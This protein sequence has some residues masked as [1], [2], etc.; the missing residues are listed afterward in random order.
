MRKKSD[1]DSLELLLDTIC[2]IFGGIILMAIL[3]VVQIN[4]SVN[5]MSSLSKSKIVIPEYSKMEFECSNLKTLLIQRESELSQLNVRVD[6]SSDIYLIMD[7][8]LKV[9]EAINDL[10]G[11]NKSLGTIVSEYRKQNAYYSE[12][13][14]K[15]KSELAALERQISEEN[16]IAD[17]NKLGQ[18]KQVRLPFQHQSFAMKSCC[19]VVLHDK[20]YLLESNYYSNIP[21][22]AGQCMVY[23]ER[24]GF[25][26]KPIMDSGYGVSEEMSDAFETSIKTYNAIG[27]FVHA[28][29]DSF[30]SFQ[31]IKNYILEKGYMY[32]VSPYDDSGLVVELVDDMPVE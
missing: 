10:V 11:D 22:Q 16:I 1:S 7:Q 28:D 24:G 17:K 21:H 4:M 6:K 32:Y 30:N 23:P 3:V 2:N 8:I 29:D 18:F 5:E 14:V 31:Q 20:L 15:I 12:Q 27:F 26:V 9:T 25:L 19:F 13:I